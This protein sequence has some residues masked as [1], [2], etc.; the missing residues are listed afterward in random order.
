MTL[1]IVLLLCLV[2]VSECAISTLDRTLISPEAV[3]VEREG[4]YSKKESPSG[5]GPSLISLDFSWSPFSNTTSPP[6]GEI[7]LVHSSL[8]NNIGYSSLFST[9]YCCSLQLHSAGHC[10]DKDR[11]IIKN[12]PTDPSA[13]GYKLYYWSFEVNN[14]LQISKDVEPEVSGI[15]YLLIANCNL[16]LRQ[17]MWISGSTTWRSPFGY[18]PAQAYGNLIV[19]WILALMYFAGLCVWC[20]MMYKYRKDLHKYQHSLT[21]LIVVSLIEEFLWALV[22][23]DYNNHGALNYGIVGVGIFFSACKLTGIRFLLLLVGLGYAIVVDSISKIALFVA[24]FIS[25]GYFATAAADAYIRMQALQQP[26]SN[27]YSLT[28]AGFLIAFN[29]ILIFW[30]CYATY[31]T[32]KKAKNEKNEKYDMYKKLIIIFGIIC[33]IAITA[34]FVVVG[35]T[36]SGLQDEAYKW[37]WLLNTY[38][39]FIYF[40]INVYMAYLWRPSPNNQR[41]AYIHVDNNDHKHVELEESIRS[42]NEEQV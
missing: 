18:I 23:I 34:F 24:I 5:D 7:L 10:T 40:S 27:S 30:I 25:L 26:T 29:A 2:C 3:F 20:G 13:N 8:G 14:S 38:W 32:M 31:T 33:G 17:D 16:G 36:F 37:Y 41:F 22:A 6:T 21:A 4:I 11:L 9:Q 42:N 1:W 39:D 28:T 12:I 15:W 19:Y 35:I